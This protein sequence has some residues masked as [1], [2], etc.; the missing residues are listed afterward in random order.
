M[1]PP[2]Y[3]T[4]SLPDGSRDGGDGKPI[5]KQHDFVALQDVLVE[6]HTFNI[7]DLVNFSV[8]VC[9]LVR[10]LRESDDMEGFLQGLKSLQKLCPG[11]TMKPS[12]LHYAK[13]YGLFVC[14]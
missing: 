12:K 10:A 5:E 4:D 11:L 2:G 9:K 6:L 7:E 3:K 1:Y 13:S 8:E 14:S